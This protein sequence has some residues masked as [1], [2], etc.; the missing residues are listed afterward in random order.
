MRLVS[1]SVLFALAPALLLARSA[2]PPTKRTGAAVDGGLNCTAC[3]RTYA[4]ANSDPRGSIKLQ[5]AAYTPGVKQTLKVT[6]SHP[7][8]FRWGFELTARLATDD[9]KQAGTFTVADGI[10]VQCEG[11]VDAPCNGKLEFASHNRNSFDK[12]SNGS[13][14]FE[15]EWTPPAQDV[16]DIAFY[17][18]GN[19]ADGSTNNQGD[20]VYTSS[21]VIHTAA[22]CALTAA[23]TITGVSNAASGAA[24]VGFNTLFSVYGTGFTVAGRARSAQ[25]FDMA[26]SGKFPQ[27]LDCVAIE[28]A[29]TRV[30]I[31]YMQD[32]QI[33][34]EGP[35][36][37]QNTTA[38]VRVVVN[39]GT[40]NEKKS[41]AVTAGHNIT[42]PAFFTF[43]GK[44]IAARHPDGTI[45]AN[46]A[47]VAGARPVKAGDLVTLYLTGLGL[48]DPT[49]QS[50]EVVSGQS[51]VTGSVTVQV[52]SAML[53][54]A[55]VPYVGLSPQSISGLYQLNV[56]IPASTDT[57]DVPVTVKVGS[58][59]TQAGTTIA[60]VKQ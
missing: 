22:G 59:S 11:D 39:P 21:A 18:A 30:P 10:R 51:L 38:E 45:A 58:A 33:N 14:T 20:R 37:A 16:G 57:G 28:V 41:A 24:G 54:A 8:A 3:H 47:V 42:S 1:L 43:G 50:G 23:P 49:Y 25:S 48:T 53:A 5:A 52:G 35:T 31:T 44:S 9:S 55:D 12:G 29:G 2:G 19:A 40:P 60:V 4:P 32:N 26:D 17:F 27:Q 7:E 6:V 56:R 34:A 36:L 15:V 13:N 46:P